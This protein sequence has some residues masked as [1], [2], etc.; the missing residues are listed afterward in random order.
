MKAVADAS[1]LI[2]P[3]K[4]PRFWALMKETVEEIFIPEAVYNEVLKGKE[5]RSPDVPVIERAI[6]EGWIKVRKV[7]LKA[8]LPE[9]LG[10]GEKEAITLMQ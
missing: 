10:A 6:E 3:A 5:I 4:L 9:D 2:H 7:A 8:K 1:S